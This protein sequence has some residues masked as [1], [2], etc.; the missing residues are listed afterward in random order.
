[1]EN[2]HTPVMI[3][4][5]ISFLPSTKSLN[6]MDATFGGGGYS[7]LLLVESSCRVYDTDNFLQ[8]R[9]RFR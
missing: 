6:V 2:S 1:M 5:I 8:C 4:E 7:K 9:H 3:N